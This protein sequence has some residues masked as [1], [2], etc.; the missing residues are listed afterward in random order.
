MYQ[1]HKNL[2]LFPR[3]LVEKA[4][5]SPFNPRAIEAMFARPANA[6]AGHAGR[7]GMQPA[8]SDG[9]YRV[10]D[11]FGRGFGGYSVPLPDELFAKAG[12]IYKEG[13]QLITQGL[14]NTQTYV[15]V[16]TTQLTFFNTIPT[17]LNGNMEQAGTISYPKSFIVRV[18]R[19]I[20]NLAASYSATAAIPPVWNDM[21]LLIF[22]SYHTF[23]VLDKQY[24]R[25]PSYIF[26]GGV[27]L[28]GVAAAATFTAPATIA[29]AGHGLADPRTCYV[30]IDPLYIETQV[31]FVYTV[32]WPTAV[33]LS[34]NQSVTVFLDGQF[35]RPVQ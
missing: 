26:P 11:I 16:T 19:F 20:I 5:N 3:A 13:M 12:T 2:G 7:A 31:S 9:S 33:D 35:V 34:A 18:P 4:H 21:S 23:R 22:N 10:N 29:A 1:R 27:G 30:L 17:A 25:M 32:D 8:L 15:D 14:W 28:G 24:Y 6:L